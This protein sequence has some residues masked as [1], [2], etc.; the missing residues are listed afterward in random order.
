MLTKIVTLNSK[1]SFIDCQA[2]LKY[3]IEILDNNVK[4][5]TQLQIKQ[6]SATI[7]QNVCVRVEPQNMRIF[8]SDIT[9]NFL[10]FSTTLAV[11]KYPDYTLV[12]EKQ[13]QSFY[14]PREIN[15][16]NVQLNIIF[17]IQDTSIYSLE[18]LSFIIPAINVQLINIQ[19]VQNLV[20]NNLSIISKIVSFNF[21]D[22]NNKNQIGFDS[23]IIEVSNNDTNFSFSE[24]PKEISN[25]ENIYTMTIK[26]QD[27]LSVLPA[28]MLN[29][30][31]RIRIAIK[32]IY[33]KYSDWVYSEPF[34]F[35]AEPLEIVPNS[36]VLSLTDKDNPYIYLDFVNGGENNIQIQYGFKIENGTISYFGPQEKFFTYFENDNASFVYHTLKQEPYF[37]SLL[38][39]FSIDKR[40]QIRYRSISKDKT[41]ANTWKY[42]IIHAEDIRKFVQFFIQLENNQSIKGIYL[43]VE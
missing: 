27:L 35:P 29:K 39:N 23:Y 34:Y 17:G 20:R 6:K 10:D 11:K 25:V 12:K 30:K 37:I 42:K 1:E 38:D 16:K 14:I 22:T 5:T 2:I 18:S 32:N 31:G 41:L 15:S 40:M 36:L 43:R 28:N 3:D 33:G 4:L 9:N 24:I 21:E 19:P 26:S 7:G 13:Q 8:S